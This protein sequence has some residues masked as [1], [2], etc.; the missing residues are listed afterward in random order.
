MLFAPARQNWRVKGNQKIF[1]GFAHALACGANAVLLVPGWG[2]EVSR[3]KALCRRLG[4][5]NRVA[6]LAPMS[7]PMLARF[8]RSVD[9]VL[10]QFELG[11]FGLIT[12]KAMACGAVVLTSYDDAH[13]TWCFPEPPPVVRCSTSEAIGLA[14]ADLTSDPE[15]RRAIGSASIA[16][17]AANHSSAIVAARL[18]QAM[19][20]AA[21][22]FAR[23]KQDLS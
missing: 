4:I 3:S 19:E 9:L 14:I 22:K 5:E 7:E 21:Q 6:W 11:V 1:E 18:K 13:N 10:D 16:W 20:I 2:Q 17:I 12:P 15:R 8:Y 23:R